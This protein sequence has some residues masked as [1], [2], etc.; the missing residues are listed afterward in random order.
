M[1]SPAEDSHRL[2]MS[3]GRRIARRVRSH[4]ARW[5]RRLGAP[6]DQPGSTRRC[7]P[8]RE[9]SNRLRSSRVSSS[10]A[11]RRTAHSEARDS[12]SAR[13]VDGR[14]GLESTDTVVSYN[15]GGRRRDDADD[16]V[17]RRRDSHECRRLH[18][19][20]RAGRPPASPVRRDPRRRRAQRQPG[21]ILRRPRGDACRGLRIGRGHVQPLAIA[22]PDRAGVTRLQGADAPRSLLSRA[23][24]TRVHRGQSGSRTRNQSPVRRRRPLRH[25]VARRFPARSTTTASR[26]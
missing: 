14:H 12:S 20:G 19:G 11:R 17:D 15:A 24:G 8:G 25:R 18:P 5:S 3:Y 22:D 2:T 4:S 13:D 16:A 6:A 23:G 21:R 10:C 26:T 1:T 7:P 9:A